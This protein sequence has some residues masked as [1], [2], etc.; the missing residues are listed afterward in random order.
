MGNKQSE[1]LIQH[2]TQQKEISLTTEKIVV[3]VKDED[4]NKF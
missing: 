3:K 4:G 2:A 1:S